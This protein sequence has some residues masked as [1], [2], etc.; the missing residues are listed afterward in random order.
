[1][2]GLIDQFGYDS[3]VLKTVYDENSDVWIVQRKI[4][5]KRKTA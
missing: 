2:L 1:M 3:K 4:I 5:E